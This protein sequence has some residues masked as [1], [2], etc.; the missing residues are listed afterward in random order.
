MK[1]IYL[2]AVLFLL[3]FLYISRNIYINENILLSINLSNFEYFNSS[4][5]CSGLLNNTKYIHDKEICEMSCNI[6][7]D[8]ILFG[9][10]EEDACKN[11][12]QYL[13]IDGSKAISLINADIVEYSYVNGEYIK[14]ERKI[15]SNDEFNITSEQI[16]IKISYHKS[17]WYYIFLPKYFELRISSEKKLSVHIIM[18]D[19]GSRY[20]LKRLIP[21]SISFLKEL[22][23]KYSYYDML[24]F[25]VVGYNSKPNWVPLFYGV[26]ENNC[27]VSRKIIFEDFQNSEYVT[28]RAE[29]FFEPDKDYYCKNNYTGTDHVVQLIACDRSLLYN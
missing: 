27:N 13:R 5:I 29:A 20:V 10:E 9:R 3:I 11:M 8:T 18:F 2:I 12:K 28:I 6:S 26:D 22:D 21:K 15:K 24:R 25:N 1:L 16:E 23:G 7:N 17:D 4:S 19:G 14:N